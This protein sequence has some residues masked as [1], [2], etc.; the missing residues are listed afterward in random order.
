MSNLPPSAQSDSLDSVSVT[1]EQFRGDIGQV[2]QYLAQALGGVAGTY[3]TESIDPLG[4]ILAGSPAL[5]VGAVPGGSDNS[6]RLANTA[7]VRALI[8]ASGGLPLSGGTLTGNL[9][10]PSLNGGQLGG[11]R[12]KLINGDFRVDQYTDFAGAN[13][14]GATK[15]IADQWIVNNVVTSG[16]F[17]AGAVQDIISPEGS[18]CLRVTNTGPAVSAAAIETALIAN[19]IEGLNTQ[20]LL[21][22][23][24][25]A[26]SLTLS[27]W[28]YTSIAGTWSGS[29]R[30]ELGIGGGAA[31]RSYPF[32]FSVASANTWTK[33]Q[34]TIPGDE[35]SAINTYTDESLVLIFDMGC[36]S[37][38]RS[39]TLNEW[40]GG[41]LTGVVGSNSLTAGAG[42]VFRIA[43]VQLESGSIATAFEHLPISQVMAQCQRYYQRGY[44]QFSGYMV[45]SLTASYSYGLS[46]P[47][48]VAPTM[49]TQL[50][51]W[52]GLSSY[53]LSVT[54][55]NGFVVNAVSDYTTIGGFALGF[56][57]QA[58]ATV[59]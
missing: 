10:V 58:S 59:W 57:W 14:I 19:P 32:A 16:I 38:W 56:N 1:R 21:Y 42:A 51:S 9:N 41:N 52:S 4:V 37:N 39:P 7:W 27:F 30:G 46:N 40:Q 28:V 54:N 24:I 8:A 5:A 31:Y 6:R 49:T 23:S 45:P 34:I 43:N 29:L 33:I 11:Q 35:N 25:N 36:G 47:M 18:F 15:Y 20:N 22:G 44:L 3:T 17:N 53:S 48:R 2:L 12:N 50:N 26:K 55:N 13:V